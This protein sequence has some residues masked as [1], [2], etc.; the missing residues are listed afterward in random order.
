MDHCCDSITTYL[1]SSILCSVLGCTKLWQFTL[2][3]YMTCIPFFGVIWEENINKYFYLPPING[4]AEGTLIISFV[5]HTTAYYGIE[6]FFGMKIPIS[7]LKQG[8]EV[9]LK[10]I[11][12]TV[13]F[14]FGLIVTS[15]M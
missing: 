12:V 13:F 11:T 9:E 5:L 1:I 7:F 4:V 10:S 15:Q 6:E 3:W 2:L 8:L 14:C